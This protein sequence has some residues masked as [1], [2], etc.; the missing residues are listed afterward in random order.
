MI[1]IWKPI[2]GYDGH[3][4]ASNMGRIKST[5]RISGNGN[6][7]SEK[8]KRQR[9]NRGYKVVSIKYLNKKLTLKVHR[10]V[11]MSFI[12]DRK[13]LQVNHIN[14]NKNDNRLDNLEWVNAK[15][16]VMHAWENELIKKRFGKDHWLSVPIIQIS[17]DDH[18]IQ[19]WDSITQASKDTGILVQ[20]I[21]SCL[22][23]KS[24]TSGKFKWQ[25]K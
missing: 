11:L 19:N 9:N 15:A 2:P 10:L 1:E 21:S 16:N 13:N 22:R 18:I 12:G 14:G 17:L 4:W 20:S 8:I 3:Y 6:F 25:Y 5:A 24:K 23:G 7:I